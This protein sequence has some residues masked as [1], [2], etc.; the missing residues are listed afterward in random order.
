MWLRLF[1]AFFE[2]IEFHFYDKEGLKQVLFVLNSIV[3]YGRLL[4]WGVAMAAAFY[5]GTHQTTASFEPIWMDIL[6]G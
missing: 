5:Y 2:D 4:L 6:T 1:F 3:F